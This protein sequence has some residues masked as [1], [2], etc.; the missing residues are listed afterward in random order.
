MCKL[1]Q[2][3]STPTSHIESRDERENWLKNCE[4]RFEYEKLRWNPALFSSTSRIP[5]MKVF[6]L[7]KMPKKNRE[8]G[9]EETK[10]F[11][12]TSKLI[13]KVKCEHHHLTHECVLQL[14]TIDIALLDDFLGDFGV[15]IQ[16]EFILRELF[17]DL[18]Y[19]RLADELKNE[20]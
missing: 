2:G 14:T 13:E 5:A 19:I 8:W 18:Q 20:F 17:H 11:K 7:R 1:K 12:I 3:E 6:H 10:N 4:L 9:E 15:I 16:C